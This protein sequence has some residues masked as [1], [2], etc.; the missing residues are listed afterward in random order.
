MNAI[1]EKWIEI[2]IPMD[3]ELYEFI[4]MYERTPPH[5][6]IEQMVLFSNY[7]SNIKKTFPDRVHNIEC[8][9]PLVYK[10]LLGGK[11]LN[12]EYFEKLK[13]L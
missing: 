1:K 8:L 11:E 6:T 7:V 5:K 9:R 12:D 10:I 3:S 2:K 13:K 4:E